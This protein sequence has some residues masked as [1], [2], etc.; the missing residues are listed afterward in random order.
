MYNYTK[1]YIKYIHILRKK[2]FRTLPVDGFRIA[3]LLE[4]LEI[5]V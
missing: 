1:L 5:R 4:T 3:K 2:F